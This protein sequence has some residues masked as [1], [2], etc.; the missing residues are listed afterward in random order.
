MLGLLDWLKGAIATVYE[1]DSLLGVVVVVA[2][3]LA[4]VVVLWLLFGPGVLSVLGN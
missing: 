2:L 3:G 4:V 1:K